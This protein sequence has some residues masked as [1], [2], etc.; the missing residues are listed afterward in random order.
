MIR[1]SLK[2]FLLFFRRIRGGNDSESFGDSI[3]DSHAAGLRAKESRWALMDRS[4][5]EGEG[6]DEVGE[7][8]LDMLE[9]YPPFMILV[10][11]MSKG[12]G[13]GRFVGTAP[14]VSL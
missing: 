6:K 10:V 12:E 11:G 14:L 5:C 2:G 4:D 1:N 7:A 9:V 13:V 8:E 3:V